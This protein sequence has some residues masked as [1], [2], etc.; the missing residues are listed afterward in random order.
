MGNPFT[1]MQ[2]RQPGVLYSVNEFCARKGFGRTYFYALVKAGIVK[3]VKV[4]RLR[5]V[6]AEADEAYDQHLLSLAA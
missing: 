1:S 4:G 3:T 5:K 2:P 6:S